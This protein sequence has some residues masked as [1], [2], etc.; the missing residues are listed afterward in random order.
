MGKIFELL[1]S[2]FIQITFLSEEDGDDIQPD[3]EILTI[4][5]NFAVPFGM[6]ELANPSSVPPLL[7]MVEQ[8]SK[9][10]DC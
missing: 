5:R 9:D 8:Q 7:Y 3:R 1:L 6:H 10:L 4:V 2:I